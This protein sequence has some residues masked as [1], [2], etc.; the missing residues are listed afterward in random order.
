MTFKETLYKNALKA[1]EEIYAK[2]KYDPNV[3]LYRSFD[4]M[5]SVNENQIKN[6]EWLVDTLLPY[7]DQDKLKHVVIL[8]SWYG[9]L[10]VMLQSKLSSDIE[11][12]NV[13]SDEQTLMFG[14][15]LIQDMGADNIRFEEND[16]GEYF[17]EKSDKFQLII[18]TSCEHMEQDDLSLII[19]MKPRDTLICF[20]GNNYDSIQSH[21]NTHDSL[22]S[23]VDSLGLYKVYHSET[24]EME[25][26]NRYMVIGI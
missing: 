25:N 6:K 20:Q 26:Y 23:F 2:S 7:I 5:N 8:G 11:I 9:L 17:F 18:N 19:S 13:D 14:R 22:E 1:I 24:L 15:K 12:R 4:I 10:S 21:I 16:A 3:D